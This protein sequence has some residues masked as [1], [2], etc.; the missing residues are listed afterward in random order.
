MTL[1]LSNRTAD[2]VIRHLGLE[3]LPGEGGYFRENYRSSRTYHTPVPRSAGT[4]IYYFLTPETFS[5]LHRLRFDEVYH[6]YLGDPA[7]LTIIDQQGAASDIILGPDIFAGQ[8]VQA[9]VPSRRWQGSR[10]EPGGRWALLG[11]TM[12]PGFDP[13]D[14]ELAGGSLLDELPHLAPRLRPLLADRRT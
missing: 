12:A 9:L 2:E 11:T 4:A 13:Q 8:C 1:P 10:L 14:F 3:P 5:A 6:F 7:R